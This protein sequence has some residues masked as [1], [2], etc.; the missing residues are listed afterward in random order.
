M[1]A[2][3]QTAIFGITLVFMLT[4]L[5]GLIIPIFPGILVIWLSALGFG[6]VTG[7]NTLGIWMF[8]LITLLAI[9]GTLVDNL[10]MTAGVRQGGAA[11]STIVLG[12]L[13]GV[14]GTFIFPPIG[15]LLLAP[16]T[17]FLIEWRK[18]NDWR[19]ALQSI[20]GL[21]VGWGLAFVA[22]FGIGVVMIIFWIIWEWKG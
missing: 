6:V 10:F 11:W 13:A 12:V 9:A 17:I 5:F 1:A 2:W 14:V 15:G 8:V 7:F 3:L 18:Q 22:R 21:A 4:G 20:R 19:K 16:L